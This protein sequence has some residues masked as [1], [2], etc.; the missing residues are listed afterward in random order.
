MPANKTEMGGKNSFDYDAP[1]EKHWQ[2][3][4]DWEG[5]PPKTPREFY[6]R[7]EERRRCIMKQEAEDFNKE[8]G[9]SVTPDQFLDVLTKVREALPLGGRGNKD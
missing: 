1:L 7:S 4:A 6:A 9:T 5:E 3:P 2:N 8:F